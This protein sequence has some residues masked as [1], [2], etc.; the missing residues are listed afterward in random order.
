[1]HFSQVDVEE[2]LYKAIILGGNFHGLTIKEETQK[3]SNYQPQKSDAWFVRI[4]NHIAELS[5]DLRCPHNFI[6]SD[7]EQV[8]AAGLC[9]PSPCQTASARPE[10]GAPHSSSWE[11]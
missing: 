7:L 11:A 9:C 1:M 4:K 10:D 3:G 2:V 8:R 5:I 6:L